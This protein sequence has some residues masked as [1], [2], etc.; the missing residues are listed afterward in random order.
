MISVGWL[1]L[2]ASDALY[3]SLLSGFAEQ[4]KVAA[5]KMITEMLALTARSILLEETEAS[6]QAEVAELLTSGD[7][8][9]ISEWLKQQPLPIT[10]SLRERLDRTILQIQ[11]E[12]AAEDSS[13]I[14]H[15]V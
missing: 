4:D 12:L 13:A 6:Y 11:A 2:Y 3:A 1:T 7:D 14:L 10:D 8:Q 5:D 15:S 9:T